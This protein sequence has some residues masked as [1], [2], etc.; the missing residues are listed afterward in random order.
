MLRALGSMVA[1][2]HLLP[3][4]EQEGNFI[5]CRTLETPSIWK[6]VLTFFCFMLLVC[7]R[8][9]VCSVSPVV[10]K[11]YQTPLHSWDGWMEY[12]LGND[13][14]RVNLGDC[15]CVVGP[16]LALGFSVHGPSDRD[17]DV[18]WMLVWSK[19]SGS[20]GWNRETFCCRCAAIKSS[21]TLF[22]ATSFEPSSES[23]TIVW[24]EMW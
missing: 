7:I 2:S 18:L 20:H 5:L 16:S 4:M 24:N 13:H 1:P 6:K 22:Q 15:G 23:W 10:S 11:I 14:V 17:D 21:R 8:A 3:F 12:M 9:F 19:T